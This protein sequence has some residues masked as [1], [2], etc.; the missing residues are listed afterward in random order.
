LDTFSPDEVGDALVED[1]SDEFALALPVVAVGLENC[2]SKVWEE[3][4][5]LRGRRPHRD[6][7]GAEYAHDHYN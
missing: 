3:K 7:V 5:M 2:F 4:L 6:Y 1:G